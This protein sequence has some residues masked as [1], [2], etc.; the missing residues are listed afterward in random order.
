MGKS[1][2][3]PPPAPDFRGAAQATAAGDAAAAR[4]SSKAN[5]PNVYTPYGNQLVTFSGD[6]PTVTQN[7]SRN[8]QRLFDQTEANQVQLN[9]LA[10]MAGDSLEGVVGTPVNF[11]GSPMVGK[12][13][14]PIAAANFGALP[15][16]RGPQSGNYR[17]VVYDANLSRVMP[18]IARQRETTRANL[19]AGGHQVGDKGFDY[20]M[21]LLDRQENDA[22][23]AAVL[24]AGQEASRDFGIDETVRTQNMAE[25]GQGFA[26]RQQQFAERGQG[27]DERRQGIAEYLAQRQTPLDEIS[28]LRSGSQI[29]ARFPGF[30]GN[31]NLRGPDFLGA[32]GL[33][34]QYNTGVY[35]AQAASSAS[36]NSGL[37]G[38]G[39]SALLAGGLLL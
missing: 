10:G 30:Q 15:G 9:S 3:S 24:S 19:I 1:A 37:F 29:Q 23:N 36:A 2:P 34:S 5:N 14:D 13:P 39:G 27:F 38:L 7:L 12:P 35:N 28:A 32:T 25:R 18:D 16:A 4:I 8:Q 26:E 33:E 20:E 21:E 17:Q 31:T 22:R 6:Q 11:S